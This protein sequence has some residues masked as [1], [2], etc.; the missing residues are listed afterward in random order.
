VRC[1]PKYVLDS[2]VY[3]DLNWARVIPALVRL[4]FDLMMVDLVRE[5][6]VRPNGVVEARE[7]RDETLSGKQVSEIYEMKQQRWT[8]GLSLNDLASFV[9]ARDLRCV[10]LA[11]DQNLRRFAGRL[12]V[13]VHGSLWIL[14]QLIAHDLLSTTDAAEALKTMLA[15]GA[16]FPSGECERRLKEWTGM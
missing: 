6:M 5:E 2:S 16:R 14:D 13:E 12:G 9:L 11:N 10:L 8:S 7:I 4:P 15:H 1:N 3:V